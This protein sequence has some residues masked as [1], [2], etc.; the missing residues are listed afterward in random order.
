M[1][2]LFDIQEEN[3][4]VLCG[5]DV[6]IGVVSAEMCL[7]WPKRVTV[8]THNAP[9]NHEI[10]EIYEIF[11][12]YENIICQSTKWAIYCLAVTILIFT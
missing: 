9:Q 7:F 12:I 11:Y 4:G 2:V 3:F 8:V 5:L 6:K 10:M 1:N